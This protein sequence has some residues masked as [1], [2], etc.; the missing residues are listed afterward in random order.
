[1]IT[2][3]GQYI[4]KFKVGEYEDFLN[5]YDLQQFTLVEE[6]GN[7]LPAFEIVFTLGVKEILSYLNE[8][9]ILE[10]AFGVTDLDMINVRLMILHR[11][12]GRVGEGL[13]AVKLTGL[14]YTLAYLN[15]SRVQ[16]TS[17]M[18]GVEAVQAAVARHFKK[19]DFNITKS[20]DSQKWIQA[21]ES[22]KSFVNKT[23]MHSFVANSF[24]CV[25]ITS[26]GVFRLIDFKKAASG[27]LDS[28]AWKFVGRDS[29]PKELREITYDGDYIFESETGFM[30]YW[31]GY[32]REQALLNL[33]TGATSTI[34]PTL[35]PILAQV[36]YLDRYAEAGSRAA[37]MGLLG[38]NVHANY[39][40]AFL[41][42]L[43]NLALFSCT[44]V[45]LSYSNV[46]KRTSVLDMVLLLEPDIGNPQQSSEQ[47][48]GKYIITRVSRTISNK[49]LTTWVRLNREA[50]HDLKGV[51]L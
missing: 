26:E 47:P 11:Q 9:N 38:E 51:F 37:E 4:L 7:V 15:E 29:D 3:S 27:G 46:F 39:H 12:I 25:G 16:I 23:W 33:D 40:K 21:N 13:Y 1:M 18:S 14:Y 22:D 43:T 8:G 36:K 30:N 34:S 44:K 10:V 20:Q 48:S 45:E 42:N 2:V 35:A 5:E 19:T 41:Q 31:Q 6:A 28:Y 24:L 17:A 50:M 49:V 32:G